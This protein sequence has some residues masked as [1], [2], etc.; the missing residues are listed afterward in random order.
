MPPAVLR[1]AQPVSAAEVRWLAPRSRHDFFTTATRLRHG[2][3]SQINRTR[4]DRCP[5][6]IATPPTDGVTT[7]ATVRQRL[8][9]L[10]AARD[11]NH[12]RCHG[13]AGCSS[14]AAGAV[15]L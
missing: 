9:Q 8:Q 10:A 1:R 2:A 3:R 5:I 15:F 13:R 12:A 6:L 4:T 7:W 14:G 11:A